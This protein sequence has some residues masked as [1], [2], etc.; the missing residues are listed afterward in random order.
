MAS[1]SCFKENPFGGNLGWFSSKTIMFFCLSLFAYVSEGVCV[2]VCLCVCALTVLS[3]DGVGV[4]AAVLVDVVHGVLH[5]VHHLD[6]AL[7]VPVLRPQGLD[8][9][10][11]EGQVGRELGP[12]MDLE[13]GR[14]SCRERVSSPV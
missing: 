1:S 7:Q 11:A 9:R 6:A 3:D 5:A 2:C 4:G 12:R 8:L 10:R 14:A 13:I